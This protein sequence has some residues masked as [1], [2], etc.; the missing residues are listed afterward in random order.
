MSQPTDQ[1]SSTPDGS[2]RPPSPQE[3]LGYGNAAPT[4]P[5]QL[6][7]YSQPAAPQTYAAYQQPP[8]PAVYQQPAVGYQ[9]PTQSQSTLYLVAAILNWVVLGITVVSTLGIGIIAAAWMVPMT[10]MIHKGAKD[11]YRHTGLAV[12][13][14]LFCGLVSGILMLVDEGNRQPK[15]L[16]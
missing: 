8:A 3:T 2:A 16:R 5:G 15:P 1:P 9:R 12:C 4:P 11:G 6:Q 10:V 14:L 7:H 13:T